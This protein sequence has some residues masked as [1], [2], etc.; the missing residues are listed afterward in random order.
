M[1]VGLLANPADIYIADKTVDARSF[2]MAVGSEICWMLH[3]ISLDPV[4][5][6]RDRKDPK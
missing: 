4:L 5:Y 1:P 2:L 6:R 3:T